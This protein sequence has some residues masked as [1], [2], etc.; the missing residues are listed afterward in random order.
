[1]T[2]KGMVVEGRLMQKEEENNP[3]SWAG[4]HT[5]MRILR[6]LQGDGTGDEEGTVQ[7]Y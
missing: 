6:R 7:A 4:H 1:M 3:V 5:S 2:L